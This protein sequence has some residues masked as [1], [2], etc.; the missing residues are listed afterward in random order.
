MKGMC[1]HGVQKIT[2]VIIDFRRKRK[3]HSGL[4][5]YGQEVELVASFKYLG[6]HISEALTWRLKHYLCF[7][8][9]Q[10]PEDLKAQWTPPR[11]CWSSIL[12]DTVWFSSWR[13]TGAEKSSGYSAP[14]APGLTCPDKLAVCSRS[15]RL[16]V[17][18][19]DRAGA[20]DRLLKSPYEMKSTW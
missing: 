8:I 14:Q 19:N 16:E 18:P 3:K 10:Q 7:R 1:L 11:N 2:Q 15:V 4:S 13:L 20:V 5:M 17:L 12:T 9:A 6:V